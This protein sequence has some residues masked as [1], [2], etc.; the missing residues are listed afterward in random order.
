MVR[1]MR[2]DDASARFTSFD[3]RRYRATTVC[4]AVFV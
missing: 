3:E 4:P 1:R 2:P